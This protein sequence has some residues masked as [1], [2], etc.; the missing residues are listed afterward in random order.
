LSS[1][2]VPKSKKWRRRRKA[3]LSFHCKNGYHFK[4]KLDYDTWDILVGA[5]KDAD[6]TIEAYIIHLLRADL[7]R[8]KEGTGAL[9]AS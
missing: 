4:V 2:R 7:R 3:I 9:R 1:H 8:F 6:M 5:A